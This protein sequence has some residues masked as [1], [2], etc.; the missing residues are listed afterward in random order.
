MSMSVPY[1]RHDHAGGHPTAAHYGYSLGQ[2]YLHQYPPGSFV[3]GGQPTV[4]MGYPVVQGIPASPVLPPPAIMGYPQETLGPPSLA[5]PPSLQTIDSSNIDRHHGGSSASNDLVISAS[6]PP[7]EDPGDAIVATPS[8]D[9]AVVSYAK[10]G[11]R[12]AGG[13]NGLR[14]E[15]SNLQED[16]ERRAKFNQL[17]NQAGIQHASSACDSDRGGMTSSLTVEEQHPNQEVKQF[18][19]AAGAAELG[20]RWKEVQAAMADGDVEYA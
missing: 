5:A 20:S 14:F 11:G 1:Q 4:A 2:P 19:V 13:R 17:L 18:D 16:H 9:S 15:E 3:Y 12:V 8:A 7:H 10:H 6:R